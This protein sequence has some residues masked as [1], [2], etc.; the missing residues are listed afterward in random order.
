MALNLSGI[1]TQA[2]IVACGAGMSQPAWP[3]L[4]TITSRRLR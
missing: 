1:G 3:K 2:N 4:S